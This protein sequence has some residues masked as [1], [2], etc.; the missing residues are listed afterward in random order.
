MKCCWLTALI[1]MLPESA[2]A[3]APRWG[4]V[5]EGAVEQ[6]ES[7][8]QLLAAELV[9]RGFVVI[10]RQETAAALSLVAAKADAVDE[11]VA[12]QLSAELPAHGVLLLLVNTR[13]EPI[14]FRMIVVAGN[15]TAS[16][17]GQ[18]PAIEDLSTA[19]QGVARQVLTQIQ[20]AQR[21][22]PTPMP[23]PQSGPSHAP[24][25]IAVEED[26]GDHSDVASILSLSFVVLPEAAKF[27]G[28]P[29][30][31]G[32][33]G[34]NEGPFKFL[35]HLQFDLYLFDADGVEMT[36]SLIFGPGGRFALADFGFVEPTLGVRID[37]LVVTREGEPRFGIE[38]FLRA[39]YLFN[40]R[41][42]PVAGFGFIYDV[43]A[44]RAT[45]LLRLGL[46]I[47]L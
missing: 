41:V 22:S 39:G 44:E 30:F 26:V 21:R 6:H 12:R 25:Y 17:L 8:A 34:I 1:L 4:I 15:A 20:L 23:Q 19:A 38:G 29:S 43:A 7:V 35:L 28:G 5:V 18:A 24:G 32:Y 47:A 2:L 31:A 45:S 27:L 14:S 40:G 42:G 3:Q 9:A 33:F 37:Q 36:S 13:A 11:Q 10:P 46:G 16:R